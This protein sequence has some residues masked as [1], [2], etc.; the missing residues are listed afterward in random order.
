[1]LSRELLYTAITRARTCFTLIA[2]R[3]RLEN[4]IQRQTRRM[5]GLHAALRNARH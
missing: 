5:S 1:V 4:A 3:A 2:P